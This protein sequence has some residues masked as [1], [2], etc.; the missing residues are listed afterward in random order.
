MTD[1]S[2]DD[3]SFPNANHHLFTQMEITLI[4]AMWN[5]INVASLKTKQF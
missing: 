1:Q 4:I 3:Q 2:N 5:A